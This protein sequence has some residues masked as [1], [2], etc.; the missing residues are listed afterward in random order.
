[1]IMKFVLKWL[2]NGAIVVLLLMYYADVSFI[3]AAATA[4]VLSLLAYFIGDQFILRSTNNIVATISDAVLAFVFLWLVAYAWNWPLSM[5][6]ILVITAMLGVAEWFIHRYVFQT[7][8][9]V[10]AA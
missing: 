7:K 4:T 1:M 10:Q 9:K 6:E 2:I 5:G 3:G 8:P